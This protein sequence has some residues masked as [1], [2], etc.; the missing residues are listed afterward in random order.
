MR[1]YKIGARRLAM[2]STRKAQRFD[3]HWVCLDP[4]L[5]SEIKKTRPCIVVS[6]DEMNQSLKTVTIAPLT[7]TIID[8]PFRTTIK[9]GQRQSSVACDQ[10]RTIDKNRLVKY[11]TKLSPKEQQAVARILQTIFAL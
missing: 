7:S 10:I 4:T 8:W 2:V 6:P 11:I 3:V 1:N 5:G 9:M